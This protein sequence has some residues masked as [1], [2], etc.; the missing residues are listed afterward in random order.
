[1][2]MEDK[3]V[4]N[5]LKK[6]D[7]NNNP[8]MFIKSIFPEKFKEILVACYLLIISFELSIQYA[9]LEPSIFFIRATNI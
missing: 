7:K 9:T 3:E 1:M 4:L 5:N 6:Y 2:M 8:E